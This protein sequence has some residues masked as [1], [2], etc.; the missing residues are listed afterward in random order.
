LWRGDGVRC[1]YQ[2]YPAVTDRQQGSCWVKHFNRS[3]KRKQPK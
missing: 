3:G 2:R 1:L